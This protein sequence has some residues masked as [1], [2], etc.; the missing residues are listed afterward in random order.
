MDSRNAADE[1]FRSSAQ[2]KFLNF[3]RAEAGDANFGNPHRQISDSLDVT[4][5]IRPF[6]NLPVIP[7]QG[8]SVHGDDI[9]MIQHAEALHPRDEFRINR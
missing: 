5:S 9:E 3:F 2:A 8:K 6:V 4:D 7:I 1:Q